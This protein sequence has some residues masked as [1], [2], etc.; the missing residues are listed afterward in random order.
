MRKK[1]LHL[2]THRYACIYIHHFKNP[3]FYKQGQGWT[4]DLTWLG[5][6]STDQLY[7]QVTKQHTVSRFLSFLDS[8][9][10]LWFS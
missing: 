6:C 1:N 7:L 2:Q 5:K 3:F 9:H 4:Q 8:S 10:F